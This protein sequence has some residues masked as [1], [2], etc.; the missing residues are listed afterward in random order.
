M[1]ETSVGLLTAKVLIINAC[2][3]KKE[4][5]DEKQQQQNRA[6]S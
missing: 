1:A 6:D 3:R 4:K 2:I 5:K